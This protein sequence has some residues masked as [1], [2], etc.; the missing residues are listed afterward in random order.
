M[1]LGAE[2]WSELERSAIEALGA[3]AFEDL[4]EAI[5]KHEVRTR[6]H[7][8]AN[9]LGGSGEYVPDG[10]RDALLVVKRKPK[11][12]K[13]AFEKDFATRAFTED[14]RTE[15]AYSFKKGKHWLNS[16]LRDARRKGAHPVEVLR[17]GG[18]FKLVV[19]VNARR[20]HLV[21]R[22]K[23]RATP[24]E[25]LVRVFAQRLKRS[26]ASLAGR[27]E[28][29]DS[30]EVHEYLVN[31][32]PTSLLER[33]AKKLGLTR[34]LDT[35][36]QWETHH[37]GER[38]K[39][40]L[41]VDAAREAERDRL[42]AHLSS[43][44]VD[45]R[46][47]VV[48]G[49]SGIG[50]T[51]FA[52][53]ALEKNPEFCGRVRVTYS[54]DQAR[55]A[56]ERD[57]TA[58][59]RDVLLIVDDCN[60]EDARSLAPRFLAKATDPSARLIALVPALELRVPDRFVAFPIG[61][62]A[63]DAV[64][65]IVL[66]STVLDAASVNEIVRRAEGYAWFAVLLAEEA[67]HQKRAPRT[68]DEAVDWVLASEREPEVGAHRETRAR[69]L[70]LI[71]LTPTLTL[72][73]LPPG[74]QDALA[75]A[76]DFTGWKD[77]LTH[78]DAASKRGL[79]RH[80]HGALYAYVTPLILE[81][82]IL[83][84]LF[85]GDHD[86]GGRRLHAADPRLHDVLVERAR[87]FGIGDRLRVALAKVGLEAL[88]A[89][90]RIADLGQRR[91]DNQLL[92]LVAEEEPQRCAARIRALVDAESLS[93]LR[94][95]ATPR[96]EM[97]WALE[98]IVI[99]RPG[100]PDA[101]AALFRLARAENEGQR[102]GAKNLWLGLY[103]A[104]VT[105]SWPLEA[106]I[107]RLRQRAEDDAPDARELALQGA[108]AMLETGMF[109]PR[110][111][112]REASRPSVGRAE[113]AEARQAAWSI[114]VH[115]AS[116]PDAAVARRA[117]RVATEQL[118]GSIRVRMGRAA[119]DATRAMAATFDET[120]RIALRGQLD[121]I[122][123]SDVL[124]LGDAAES[125]ERLRE[126]LFP[127]SFRERLRDSLGRWPMR[128][129]VDVDAADRSLA[130]ESV[131]G[132]LPI[133][134]ELEWVL[135]DQA[136]RG[137]GFLW[138]VGEED[139][140]LRL[141]PP[142]LARADS[143]R[144]Q[145][146]AA[147]Y[148]GGVAS[149]APRERVD[150]ILSRLIQDASRTTLAIFASLD[151][152][153][154]DAR[155]VRL[156]PLLREQHL[157]P[158]GLVE[159]GRRYRP[160][161][162][163]GSSAVVDLTRALLTIGS[164]ESVGAAL[165]ILDKENVGST[166]SSPELLA[167]ASDAVSAAAGV[168]VAGAAEHHW[169]R[170]AT[171]LVDAGE[172]GGTARAAFAML[173]RKRGSVRE[174]W[175]VIQHATEKDPEAAWAELAKRLETEPWSYLVSFRFNRFGHALPEETVLRWVGQDSIRAM[176][177]ATIIT[178]YSTALHP[179]LRELIRRFG[180]RSAPAGEI[181][182]RMHSTQGV[183]SSLALDERT[184]LAYAQAWAKDP[185]PEVRAFAEHLAESLEQSARL[186]EAREEAERRRFGT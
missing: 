68:L 136:V 102:T 74:Q 36:T 124:D 24:E 25:H 163:L 157:D 100:L 114:L 135:G 177:V 143:I 103:A 185:D 38:G 15:T 87:S 122:A 8:S 76:L 27:I 131:S 117:K 149:W 41:Q 79:V 118:R 116:D 35:F 52:Q 144:A 5:L 81:R 75:R 63:D 184:R 88:E 80:G 156:L 138:L 1:G 67:T 30:A 71:A 92:S 162:R 11:R 180:A 150:T 134:D 54:F 137:R 126:T 53:W 44:A 51:R 65:Q 83:I 16:A 66:A 152:G 20:G 7:T 57:V 141:L 10:G 78:R 171:R 123:S 142:L 34:E 37:D 161:D 69:A 130:R 73:D 178:P 18:F 155:V 13:F 84:R 151:V 146:V 165:Q 147:G 115:G 94:D 148:V 164:Q 58:R 3:H 119:I 106:R 154:D 86:P 6:H 133:L 173:A 29:L 181:E 159:L 55:D 17:R 186:S 56:I 139:K 96:Q 132:D 158:A 169:D 145:H 167:A 14:E 121:E 125:F 4:V 26:R 48:H 59:L 32:R 46:V 72:E 112:V 50:K 28:I 39:P 104:V 170:V 23:K 9:L 60:E 109:R 49:P 182:S 33:F 91:I 99:A 95:P 107:T 166:T 174:V 62:L 82:E 47:V 90:N 97:L 31:V 175:P 12:S 43:A 153:L 21:A 85:G 101:E 64:A 111:N 168:E 127:R 140:A 98:L 128:D 129:E 89:C 22:D 40:P 160:S 45:N 61:R 19:G 93:T 2:G 70:A 113:V 105:E 77:F 176:K 183:V 179:I 120:E 110:L 172:V 108:E 42:L